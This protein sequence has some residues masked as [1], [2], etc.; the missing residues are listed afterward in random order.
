MHVYDVNLWICF[1]LYLFFYEKVRVLLFLYSVCV[2]V[3]SCLSSFFL[4]SKIGVIMMWVL[5]VVFKGVYFILF[6][7]CGVCVMLHFRGAIFARVWSEFLFF[8]YFAFVV[9]V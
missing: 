1:V 6:F 4:Y 9:F 7:G 8:V 2:C 5:F 3:C